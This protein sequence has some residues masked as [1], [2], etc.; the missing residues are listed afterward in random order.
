MGGKVRNVRTYSYEE[1]RLILKYFFE[2]EGM[3]VEKLSSTV[4]VSDKTLYC[5][6]KRIDWD[7]GKVD[8]PR[9]R[10]EK[11]PSDLT[12]IPEGV[13]AELREVLKHGS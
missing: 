6:L 8:R 3:T 9:R 4:N 10:R 2:K 13:K 11:A 5:W 12:D 1:K 7:F